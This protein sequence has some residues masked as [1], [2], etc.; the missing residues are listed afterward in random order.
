MIRKR[1]HMTMSQSVPWVVRPEDH[2]LLK[3]AAQVVVRR[4]ETSPL[5]AEGGLRVARLNRKTEVLQPHYSAADS[6]N[7]S[8]ANCKSTSLPLERE[9][10]RSYGGAEQHMEYFS[11]CIVIF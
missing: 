9:Q 11:Q 8:Q 1:D 6:P 10:A 7:W 2:G 4:H 5:H 3:E